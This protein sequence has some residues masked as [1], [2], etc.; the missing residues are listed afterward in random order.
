[1]ITLAYAV[2]CDETPLRVGPRK[3]AAGKK[4]AERYLLVA[5]TELYTHYLLGDRSLATFTAS[6][7]TD[8]AESGSVIVH[9]RYQNYECATRRCCCCFPMEVKDRPFVRRRS[10]EEKLEAA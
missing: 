9:D 1:M 5:C 8:L 10:D 2:C 6:V 4:K 7:L 3:P